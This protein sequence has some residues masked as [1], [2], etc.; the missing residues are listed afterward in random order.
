VGAVNADLQVLPGLVIPADALP[1]KA[2][3][4]GGPGGQNVNK[5]ATKVELRF[6]FAAFTGLT[7]AQKSRLRA[8]ARTQ[9]DANG[10]L[11]VTSQSTRSQAQNLSLAREH[12]AAL[13]RAALI[14]PKR[15]RATRPTRAAKARRLEQKRKTSD[16]KR[17]R[18][19]PSSD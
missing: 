5:V 3:R 16:K 18:R 17:A 4:S 19:E 10:C 11:L 12:V 1:W 9:L 2:V 8:L 7:E 15:R 14:V 6:D 13:V